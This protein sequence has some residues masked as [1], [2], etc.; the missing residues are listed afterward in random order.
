MKRMP[1]PK[2]VG[3][4]CGMTGNP[5]HTAIGNKYLPEVD[6]GMPSSETISF[7]RYY[8]GA[9]S[10]SDW[11]SAGYGWSH[12]FIRGVVDLQVS[13]GSGVSVYRP[14]GKVFYFA[15][16]SG[17]WSPTGDIP[18]RLVELKDAN[19]VRTGWRYTIAADDSVETYTATGKLLT[20]ADRS[21]RLQT[22]TYDLP[23]S[24]GGDGVPSTLDTVTDYSGRQLR[25]SY[26]SSKR[27]ST[28]TDPV[29]GVI[30]YG[31]DATGN[32]VSV[33]YPDGRSKTYHYNEP[34]H[35]AG[36][37]LPH[38]LTGITDENGDRYAT[39]QYRADGK[40]VSTGHAG[41]A[42]LHTLTYGTN[43]S[44]VTDPLGTQRTHTFTT[45][46]GVVK[47]TGQSQPGGSG[48]GPASSATTYDANGNIASRA[49][50]NGNK[51]C[52]AHDLSRNLE[53][54]R[55]EG[56]AAATACP[57]NLS[58]YNPVAGTAQRKILTEWHATFRLP[59]R[60][61]EAGRETSYQYDTRG[62]LTSRSIKDT[63]T[64]ATRTWTTSYTYH[65]TVPGV[66]TQ[67]IDN[68]PR[69]DVSDISTTDYYAP[70]E[71]CTGGHFGCRSQV[72]QITNALGH[73]TS[74]TRYNAHGQPEEII[75]PNGLVT[76]LTYDARQRLL[77]RTVGTE[78]TSYQYDNA[79]QLILLTRPDGSTLAYTHDAAH[80]LTQI[81]D[82]LGNKIAYTLDTAGNRTREEVFD[83]NNALTQTRQREYD[84]LNRLWKELGAQ[85]QTTTYQYDAQG[86][87]KQAAD[88]LNH[89]TGYQFDALNRLIRIT[90]PGTG[91][92][93]QTPDAL[94]RI[95]GV[96]DPKGVA[97]TYAYNGL[98][99]LVSEVSADRGTTTY[100]YDSAG[101]LATRTDARGVKHTWT[102]DALNRPT[103]RTHTTVTGVPGTTQ[104][105]WSYDA[106]TNAKGRL[107]GMTDETGNTS[108]SHD[109]HGRLLSKT[110]TST[111]DALSL[112]H[113]LGQA[114]AP[115]GRLT[116][117][118][119]PG[120]AVI[121]PT[122][123]LDGRP[124]ALQVNGA[125]LISN[126][127][128]QPFGPAK[129]WTWGNGTSYTRSVDTDGRVSQ[130]PV[131]A[132]TRTLAFD[133]ASRI[134]NFNHAGQPA[135]DHAF[136]YDAVDRLTQ[137][138]DNIGASLW[139]Y[140]L[141]GNRTSHQPGSNTYT[142][143]Y[144]ASSNRLQSVSGPVS[145]TY[146]YDAA[147]NP[148]SDG[149][150]AFTFNAAGRLSKVVRSGQTNQY[151]HNALGERVLKSGAYLVNGP[152]RFMY[153]SEGHLIGEYDR[154]NT[155]RQETVWLGDTPIA[156][157][158]KNAQGQYQTFYV[159]ADHLNTPRAILDQQNR[160]VW[161]WNSNAFGQGL[162]EEDPD[163]DG[164]T[165]EYNSRY[166]GQ[167][168]DRETGLHYNIHR[169]YDPSTG[170]YVEADPI[171]LEGGL[172][173]YGYV[174]G[175]PLSY[176]DPLGLAQIGSRPLDFDWLPGNGSG[177]L[178]HDQI[179][180]D[181]KQSPDNSGF[182]D[183][184]SIRADRGHTRDE[185]DFSR[186][187]RI[188]DDSL[189][190]EAEKNIR[191]NWDMDWRLRRNDCQD[192]GDAAR[193]EYDRLLQQRKRFGAGR[194]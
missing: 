150:T 160:T 23:A 80:R 8:N 21:G 15:P 30:S 177:L 57:T 59:T 175:N 187:P 99:D 56:L 95:T 171:G 42:D 32:L 159:H 190:R 4:A 89:A 54:A 137:E 48:C 115:S 172:N 125:V 142:Y 191:K 86:N 64:N 180:Y 102:W 130:Y 67:K 63:A 6:S 53:T 162:P 106:G 97:T 51:T 147:G 112:T 154:N 131:G 166:P 74:I 174:G 128:Y 93:Q 66:L 62:N 50:F 114:Y 194:R 98:G 92:T 88:P 35:T 83:P 149:T 11:A 14:D 78:T 192:Y 122:H 84:A 110:Q 2:N 144:P 173:L 58:T 73:V 141:N 41:G 87:L 90:D 139:T 127:V 18:D 43:S 158:K 55:V 178:R 9:T 65:A 33:T 134:T 13:G 129:S 71:N 126:I 182:F 17:T 76:A 37:N 81:A 183:D 34:E 29:G 143:T 24:S 44:T 113:T 179:W 3:K 40:A 133:P 116:Q 111:L 27:I 70:D 36:A 168:Y 151:Y 146:T 118:T 121:T 10:F 16:S 91:Q 165:F 7:Q 5:V 124:V 156:V 167:Y 38:A 101:N 52:Y 140:D 153:D 47:S 176:T 82:A 1:A 100:T 123:G 31:Y 157:L 72:R 96:T 20:I 184:D 19:G 138:T 60:I 163:G 109:Q 148:L 161:K 169:D 170:R 75:D 22:L 152:W 105:T 77:S 61:T 108:F 68:G 185:F 189:M 85:S 28:V 103:M 104:L 79:G 45:I 39:Y 117:Q 46:L 188:Y 136:G 119:Y 69:T 181:D 145:K 107:T 26:D 164:T 120:G 25:F 186:D 132:V 135:L 12:S 49:D 155:L 193:R 94:D